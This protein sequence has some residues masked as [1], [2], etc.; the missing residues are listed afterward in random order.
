[1]LILFDRG[2]NQAEL[3][4][5]SHGIEHGA[6]KRDC[7]TD[8]ITGVFGT[9]RR[10]VDIPFVSPTFETTVPGI[11]IAG[12]L[13]GMELIRNAIEQGRLAVG[14]VRKLD[15]IGRGSRLDL[16]IVGAGPAGF[17][18]S[19]AARQHE[20]HAVTIER[21][22]LGGTVAHHPRGSPAGNDAP[23]AAS[24]DMTVS[25]SAAANI[26]SL[27]PRSPRSSAFAAPGRQVIDLERRQALE[28]GG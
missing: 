5:P 15:G 9:E 27:P 2:R 14:A 13:R 26:S 1:M 18:A 3:T 23:V 24:A 19:L 28:R 4:N 12:E 21:H 10:G 11:V 25:P 22:T 6:C 8:F 16:V 7:P 20:L 17:S